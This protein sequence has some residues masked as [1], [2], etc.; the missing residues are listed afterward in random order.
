MNER[1]YIDTLCYV[2]R[3]QYAQG[4]GFERVLPA[5]PGE[6]VE[7]A[8]DSSRT[9]ARGTDRVREPEEREE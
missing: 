1:R 7:L 5:D 4:A 6:P 2:V 3:H 8:G 9:G